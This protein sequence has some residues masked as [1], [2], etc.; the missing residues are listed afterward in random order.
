VELGHTSFTTRSDAANNLIVPM[1][2]TRTGS[3]E[4]GTSKA[5]TDGASDAL[6]ERAPPSRSDPQEHP[7]NELS[8]A[9]PPTTQPEP[10]TN[11][12]LAGSMGDRCTNCGSPLASDQRYC[13]HCG[14]RRG[15]S[16]FS[17][18]TLTSPAATGPKTVGRPPEHHRSWPAGATLIAGIATLLLAMGVGVLI[19]KSGNT[20]PKAPAAQVITINGGGTAATSS[21]STGASVGGASTSTGGS[22]HSTSKPAHTV[23]K[24]ATKAKAK[25][26]ASSSKPT[27]AA[28]KKAS[29]AASSVLGGGAGQSQ[30]TVT[31][32]SSCKAGTAGCQGG[33]FS[34]NF[35]GGG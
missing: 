21:G 16:R 29:S 5:P 31:T 1:G 12:L 19:G 32:G 27:T 6:A 28:V 9:E 14:E 4:E 13:V 10:Q 26:A 20:T 24:E 23:K 15:G 8:R 3:H 33:H 22:H 2:V 30:N 25:A 18:D 17:T 35:F 34:G 7:V 11:Q